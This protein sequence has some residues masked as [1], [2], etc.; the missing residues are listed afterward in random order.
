MKQNPTPLLTDLMAGRFAEPDESSTLWDA[1]VQASRDCRRQLRE[2]D[3]ALNNIHFDE[4]MI[5]DDTV[6]PR[7]RRRFEE[8]LKEDQAELERLTAL[9]LSAA[10]ADAAAWARYYETTEAAR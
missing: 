4:T 3:Y 2:I 8:E 5:A 6:S 9:H 7:R 1:A 10:R